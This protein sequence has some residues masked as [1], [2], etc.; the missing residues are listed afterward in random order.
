[1]VR[2][3][4]ENEAVGGDGNDAGERVEAVRYRRL[5][6]GVKVRSIDCLLEVIGQVWRY[7]G[8]MKKK[9]REDGGRRNLEF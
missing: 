9:A 6:F 4:D 8:V 7:K 5:R 2:A 1:M 3:L